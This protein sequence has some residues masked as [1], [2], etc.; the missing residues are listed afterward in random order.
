MTDDQT[1]DEHLYRVFTRNFTARDIAVALVSFDETAPAADVKRF[2][3]ERQFR[4]VG[5][6]RHGLVAGFVNQDELDG[7]TCG[8]R[9]H[10]IDPDEVIDAWSPFTTIIAMLRDRERVFVRSFGEI[11]GIV[12]RSDL[13]KPPVR[14]WL[15]GVITI[16]EMLFDRIIKPRF[17]NDS[18]CEIIS[19]GRL[20]K[21]KLL[22]DER[23][24]RNQDLTLLDCLQFSDKGQLVAK[25]RQLRAF[26]GFASR[27]QGEEVI[28]ELETLR[29]GLAHSQSIVTGDWN[30][31]VKL[32]DNLRRILALA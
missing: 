20:E 28:K 16:I 10:A 4:I 21:A 8:Q 14:M 2:M 26:V 19:A 5:V 31:I 18:W 12:S 24:R 1:P 30:T 6:R 7:E 27:R 22:F 11:H 32:A 9:V 13:Q 3:M 15:F 29:N 25:D 17:P 23:R